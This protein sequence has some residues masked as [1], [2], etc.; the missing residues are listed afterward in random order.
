M[1]RVEKK[2]KKEESIKE[3]KLE[4]E[5]KKIIWGKITLTSL[6]IGLGVAITAAVTV[7]IVIL[8]NFLLKK[9][10]EE[11]ILFKDYNKITSV[12]LNYLIGRSAEND[13]IFG[14]FEKFKE[15]NKKI[16]DILYKD[17]FFDVVLIYFYDSTK[18]DDDYLKEEIENHEEL[19]EMAFF[20]FD[21]SLDGNKDSLSSY[22]YITNIINE[23]DY[24]LLVFN[25]DN[26]S[27]TEP[28]NQHFKVWSTKSTITVYFEKFLN[29]RSSSR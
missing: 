17:T 22:D 13:E 27:W 20:L 11:N 10:D 3:L 4:V 12:E 23:K 6:W 9:D 21:I 8:V 16:Y 2:T 24:F 25:V 7:L 1:A 18:I 14:T 28:S 15:S 26:G 19:K 5:K 29:E